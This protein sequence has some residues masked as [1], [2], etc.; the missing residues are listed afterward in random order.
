M[1]VKFFMLSNEYV[2]LQF[3]IYSLSEKIEKVLCNNKTESMENI[4][5][6]LQLEKLNE[7]LH[8]VTLEIDY[9]KKP[10]EEG[11]LVRLT[12]GRFSLNNNEL[13]CG[14]PIEVWWNEEERWVVGRVEYSD[15]YYF[16][17]KKM[18]HPK[19]YD[20]MKVRIRT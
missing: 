9:Y 13:S 18:Q 20:G 19:L 14:Y 6:I 11:K 4:E 7:Q 2:S 16:Y 12:N 17:N 15:E 10:V 1:E 3:N 5:V 8:D